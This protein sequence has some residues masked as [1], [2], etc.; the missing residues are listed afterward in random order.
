MLIKYVK[1]RVTVII[2]LQGI[3]YYQIKGYMWDTEAAVGS[4]ESFFAH[5]ITSKQ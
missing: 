3:R 2:S 5:L 1:D 4:D